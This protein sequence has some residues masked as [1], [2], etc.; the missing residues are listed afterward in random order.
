MTTDNIWNKY[1]VE[2]NVEFVEKCRIK[3]KKFYKILQKKIQ[4]L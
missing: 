4:K 2:I 1:N 3:K